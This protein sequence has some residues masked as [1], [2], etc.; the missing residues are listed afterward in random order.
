MKIFLE[1]TI[2]QRTL[3][4]QWLRNIHSCVVDTHVDATE[5]LF[6]LREHTEH[7]VI[8]GEVTLDGRQ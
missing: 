1:K 4:Q 2:S 8:L 6:D 5:L 7:L 3:T